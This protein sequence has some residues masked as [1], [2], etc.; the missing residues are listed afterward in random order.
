MINYQIN[1]TKHLILKTIAA[2]LIV[3]FVWYDISW[4]GDLYYY[5]L[6]HNMPDVKK[7]VT[8]YDLLS[9]DKKESV[10]RKL[11]P[12]GEDAEQSQKFAPGYIQEQQSK[13]EGIIR[14]KQQ[15]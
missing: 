11:L 10:A 2:V 5:N 9:Y 4:A 13:H 15:N 1:P 3:A 6:S 14:Q 7:E 8:N 12:T